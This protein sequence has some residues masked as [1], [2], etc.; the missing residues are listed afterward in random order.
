MFQYDG[1]LS[2][3]N[4]EFAPFVLLGLAIV[5]VFVAPAPFAVGYICMKRPQVT[6]NNSD[7]NTVADLGIE[8]GGYQSR[9]AQSASEIFEATPSLINGMPTFYARRKLASSSQS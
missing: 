8:K 1:S 4:P 7:F 9:C 2:C 3:T 6:I 5:L